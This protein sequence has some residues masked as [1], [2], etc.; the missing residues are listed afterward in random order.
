MLPEV[1]GGRE[2]E[3][4]RAIRIK[5]DL[6][7]S[8]RLR[9][10]HISHGP[11]GPWSFAH[12]ASHG[13]KGP[14]AKAHEKTGVFE[15]PGGRDHKIS[16][17]IRIKICSAPQHKIILEVEQDELSREIRIKQGS[18]APRNAYLPWAVGS[19]TSQN[20]RFT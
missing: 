4:S 13:Q 9:G 16:R 2:T 19:D 15:G 12:E 10:P 5:S 6:G 11:G 3:I 1:A 8:Q 17:S 7:A 14:Y 20:R 18:A